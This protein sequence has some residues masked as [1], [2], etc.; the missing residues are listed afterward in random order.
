[1]QGR[2]IL[3][4]D[5]AAAIRFV[6]VISL[7]RAGAIVIEA[8]DGD[9][10]LH[11]ALQGGFD[12]ILMDVQMPGIDGPEATQQLRDAGFL[13]LPILALT[14]SNKEALEACLASGMNGVVHKPFTQA[15]LISQVARH[16]NHAAPAIPYAGAKEERLF[17]TES[18]LDLC[19]GDTT[20]MKRMLGIAVQELP[21][22]AQ[23]MSIA[24]SEGDLVQVKRL[25]HRVRPCIQG[26]GIAGLP[27]RL[28]EIESL[29]E[30]NS[31]FNKLNQLIA[32]V[33]DEMELIA[34][35]IIK[36]Q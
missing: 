5:D 4:A 33:A 30:T 9:Q 6:A 28:M 1:M 3:V 11:F 27:G 2:R 10:A 21:F 7:K 12:L 25:A 31:S 14:G 15:S 32:M 26:L 19:G 16:L 36:T 34:R 29:I 35:Q 18:L 24:Y 13:K 23:Q 17:S 22:A 20:F 8:A